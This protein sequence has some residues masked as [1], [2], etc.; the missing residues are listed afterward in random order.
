MNV[1]E[2]ADGGD[3]SEA[4]SA[5]G[6]DGHGCNRF[7]RNGPRSI[8]PACWIPSCQAQYRRQDRTDDQ[9]T[10]YEGLKRSCMVTGNLEKTEL[11]FLPGKESPIHNL[12]TNINT[13]ACDSERTLAS[14]TPAEIHPHQDDAPS[15]PRRPV[16]CSNIHTIRTHYT[17]SVLKVRRFST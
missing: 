6:A 4:G 3:D 8:W 1:G 7:R 2:T 15:S 16:L 11:L 10:H 13:F 5:S 14:S 12:S 9:A 17:L